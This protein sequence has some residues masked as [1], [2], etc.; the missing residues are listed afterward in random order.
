[1]EWFSAVIFV[2]LLVD[3]G[4][5][6]NY[7]TIHHR[8]SRTLREPNFRSKP[9]TFRIAEGD[10]ARLPCFVDNLGD[11][12]VV[13]RKGTQ[14]LAAGSHMLIKDDR[15]RIQNNELELTKI[16]PQDAGDFVCQISLSAGDTLEIAHTVE[17]LVPP[18]IKPKPEDGNIVVK[19]G[20]EVNLECTASG[21]PVPTITWDKQDQ[22]M[23]EG[24]YSGANHHVYKIIRVDRFDDGRY[25]CTADNQVGR[26]AKAHI[27]LKVLYEPEIDVEAEKVHSGLGKEAHLT[28]IVHGE[29]RPTVR[30]FKENNEL[31]STNRIQIESKESSH[32]HTLKLMGLASPQDFGNYSCVA[33]NSLGS[34]KRHIEVHG[35]P[36]PAVFRKKPHQSGKNSYRL[37]WT[38]DS[39]TPIQ[40]YRLLYR[41]IKPFH[42]NDGSGSGLNIAGGGNDWTNII[43]P[44][45]ANSSEFH[46]EKTFLLADLIPEAQYECLVQAK[47]QYG[48][49][50]ASRIHRFITNI[51]FEPAAR[52]LGWTSASSQSGVLS[53]SLMSFALLCQR[54]LAL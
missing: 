15:F 21:N 22:A 24:H 45:D 1:M 9:Q 37:V 35:R 29:P 8:T 47:N 39:Y 17:V 46:H 50:E 18:R 19:K 36:T 42:P 6:M 43:I 54:L 20:T 53:I 4:N 34:S 16:F 10:A 3:P 11:Y 52:D 25:T 48:W 33:E 30:W 40:E 41:Q 23:P 51:A 32:R 7:N 31:K 2:I 5:G 27:D 38:V 14:V 49:S 28:C 44:G 13:W 12:T 26:P